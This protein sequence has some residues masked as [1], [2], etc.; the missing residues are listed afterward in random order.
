MKFDAE[1]RLERILKSGPL[2]ARNAITC[3]NFYLPAGYSAS[4]INALL[5]HQEKMS[6][7]A[8]NSNMA[9]V[10]LELPGK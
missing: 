9:D 8:E 6:L 2:I 3:A 7:D 4:A 5:N 1:V 10:A